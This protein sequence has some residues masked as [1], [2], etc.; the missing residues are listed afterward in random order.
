[1]TAATRSRRSPRVGRIRVFP[2]GRRAWPLWC[3]AV[4]GALVLGVVITGGCLTGLA[5]AGELDGSAF[6][7][8]LGL[9]LLGTAVAGVVAAVAA[10]SAADALRTMRDDAVARLRTGERDPGTAHRGVRASAEMS[11]L[12]AALE[13]LTLRMRVADE[14]AQRSRRDAD[15][16]SAGMF[17]L[18][19]GAIAAEEGARGQLAAELHDTVAQSLAVA[20]G[21]LADG[22][23]DR[24]RAYLEEAEDQ[25]RGI[26]ARTRPPALRDGDLA[27]AV[28]GLRSDLDQRYAL[29]VDLQWPAVPRPLPMATAVTVYR[30]FQESLLNVVKHAEVDVA[31]ASLSFED[32]VLVASVR[33]DGPGF[34]PATVTADRGRHVG[35]GLLRDRVRLA[36]GGLELT[37]VP[38]HGTRLV[39]TMPLTPRTGTAVVAPTEPGVADGGSGGGP[40]ASAIAE[41]GDAGNLRR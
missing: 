8:C 36:G 4:A 35:L 15:H 7:F 30:F 34:D 29:Q 10:D 1:M 25:V 6:A 23:V 41:R 33:D 37:S 13:A 21:F 11:E 32:D 19:S 24:A 26:M 17:E 28:A 12:D 40:S 22:E 18:L 14:I 20:R 16:A 5:V 31:V 9:G 27:A 2:R 3:W 39:M 38:G